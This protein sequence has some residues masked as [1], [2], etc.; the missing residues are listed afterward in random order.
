[1]PYACET[2][3]H[4]GEETQGLLLLCWKRNQGKECS[5]EEGKEISKETKKVNT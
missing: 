5:E 2:S 1:M 3:E 4:C